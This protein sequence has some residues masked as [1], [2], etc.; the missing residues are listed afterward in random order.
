MKRFIAFAMVFLAFCSVGFTQIKAPEKVDEYAPFIA[1]SVDDADGYTWTWFK[2]SPLMDP[3]NHPIAGFDVKVNSR[4]TFH[5]W[6]EPGRY[7]LK[8]DTI[9]V[10][11]DEKRLEQ[12]EH[13]TYFEIVPRT[14]PGPANKNPVAVNDSAKTAFN[15][16]VTV[17]V[18]ANDSDPDGDPLS[19]GSFTQ[20]AHGKVAQQGNALVYTPGSGFSG[21]DTYQYTVADGKGGSATGVVSVT[22]DDDDVPVPPPVNAFKAHVK[23]ALNN[24]DAAHLSYQ[25]KVGGVYANIASQAKAQPDSWDA[26]TMMNVSKIDNQKV[27]PLAAMQG[28]MGF[29]KELG[30]ALR[31]LELTPE[32]LDGHIKAFEDI[33]AVLSN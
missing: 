28:W 10:Y 8:L 27:L 16:P 3:Q 29:F 5:F 32:D 31:D 12:Q 1:E 23:A 4:K 25:D 18:L 24:V 30:N 13:T 11:W 26:A 20:G 9:K 22:V 2:M 15:T 7:L 21:T 19:I 14:Q 6:G 33:A 17:T